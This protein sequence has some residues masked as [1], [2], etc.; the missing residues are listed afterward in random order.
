MMKFININIAVC[1]W[2]SKNIEYQDRS[3]NL[4]QTAKSLPCKITSSKSSSIGS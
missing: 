3:Y 2:L 1:S 4:L